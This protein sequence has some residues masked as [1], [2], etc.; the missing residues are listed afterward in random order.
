MLLFEFLSKLIIEKHPIFKNLDIANVWHESEIPSREKKIIGY[1][2][3]I[4]DEGIDL[5]IKTKNNKYHV[6][7]SKF[8][9]NENDTLGIGKKSDLGT[10]FNLANNICKNIENIYIL[11]TINSVPKKIKLVPKNCFFIF[12][13][14]FN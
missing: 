4:G 5:L 10:T 13:K 14:I 8:R 6:V 11:A 2:E 3:D 9:S 1:P 7:Q 12:I